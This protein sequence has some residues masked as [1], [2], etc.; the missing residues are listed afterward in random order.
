VFATALPKWSRAEPE[1][2]TPSGFGERAIH[3]IADGKIERRLVR[4][5]R[6]VFGI[7]TVLAIAFGWAIASPG[8]TQYPKSAA[9]PPS[10]RR[11]A[12]G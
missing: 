5:Y 9:A 8:V 2:R 6:I 1:R 7:W 3:R 4:C 10:V 11:R 12:R